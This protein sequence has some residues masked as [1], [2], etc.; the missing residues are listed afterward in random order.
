MRT[1]TAHEGGFALVSVVMLSALIMTLLVGYYILTHAEIGSTRATMDSTRGFYAAE[2]G[3]NVRSG[4]IRSSFFDYRRP[5]GASP[6]ETSGTPCMNGNDGG[7]DY[8]CVTH[9]LQNRAVATY[10][11]EFPGNP[12]AMVIPRGEPFQN[13]TAQVYSYRISSVARN[14]SGSPEAILE[15]QMNTRLVPLFQFA[16]FYDKD[17]EI[18]PGPQMRLSGPV[19]TNGDLYVDAST[20]LDLLGQVTTA[21]DLFRG[22]KDQDRCNGSPVEVID[23]SVLRELPGCSGRTLIAQSQLAAWNGMVRTHDESLDIPPAGSFEPQTGRLYWDRADI[24]IVLDLDDG[25]NPVIEVRNPD[26]S[27]DALRSAALN[28]C[29]AIRHL[30]DVHNFREDTDMDMMDVNVE[31]L[32]SCA[33]NN[34]LLQNNRLLNDTTDGG[35]VLYLGIEGPDMNGVNNYAVRVREAREIAADPVA[36]VGAPAVQGLTVVTNQAMYVQGD[37]NSIEKKPAAF[38]ADSLNILSNAWDDDDSDRAIGSRRASDTT[39]NAALLAGTDSTGGAEGAGG[40]GGAG[41]VDYNGGLENYPRFHENWSGRTLT[42]RGSFVSLETPQHVDGLWGDQSY[43][44]PNRD[45]DYDVDFNDATGL[46]PLTPR[47]IYLRQDLFVR[48]FEL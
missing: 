6:V 16:A 15:M 7:G 9:A 34:L 2:A 25:A 48:H 11:H 21:G 33:H 4:M 32:L 46:P 41:G 26:Q 28:A 27:V 43:N 30:D 10:I 44:P 19:H 24:R 1:R 20:G 40:Q 17:L 8:R 13:L 45:W 47:A 36:A 22:R 5:N 14:A 35:L 3:L 42:Y 31:E 12:Q 23:P 39:I 38:L 18:L 29:G 37:Y